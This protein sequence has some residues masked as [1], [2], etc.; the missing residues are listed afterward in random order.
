[1]DWKTVLVLCSIVASTKA[2]SCWECSEYICPDVLCEGSLVKGVCGC[3]NVCSKQEG[4][5]CGGL[6][7][8][9]GTCEKD[10][11]CKSEKLKPVI[12][13]D[14]RILYPPVDIQT[15][16]TCRKQKK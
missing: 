4:E 15:A 8:H 11:E 7:N 9:A 1:M 2:F 13:Q 5:E 3:C 6:G 10:L 14:G 12:L 16:G